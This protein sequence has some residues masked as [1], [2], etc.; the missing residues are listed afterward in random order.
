MHK[1]VHPFTPIQH[2]NAL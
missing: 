1:G 2:A